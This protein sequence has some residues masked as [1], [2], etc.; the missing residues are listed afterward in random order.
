MKYWLK[1]LRRSFYNISPS[2]KRIKY[3]EGML[4]EISELNKINFK[5]LESNIKSI[6]NDINSGV[7][8]ELGEFK[9]GNYHLK[10]DGKIFHKDS[11]NRFVPSHEALKKFIQYCSKDDLILDLGSGKEKIHSEIM[12]DSGLS[13]KSCDLH[14]NSDYIGFYEDMKFDKKFDAIWCSHTL[15]HVLN[16][17]GFLEKIKNDINEGGVLAITVPP[18]KHNIVGGHVS[19][20][21]P[22]LLLYR[23]ILAGF[24]CSQAEVKKYGYNISVVMKVKKI[25]HNHLQSLVYDNGDIENLKQYFPFDAKQNF[26]GNFN[27]VNWS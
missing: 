19:L 10:N 3:L 17:H 9:V 14:E 15:E 25:T 16:P 22:G 12:I 8:F 1:K 23:L 11:K 20:F 2:Y 24:D 27:I 6:K 4:N 13:P 21:N 7:I 26:N 18:L 5:N